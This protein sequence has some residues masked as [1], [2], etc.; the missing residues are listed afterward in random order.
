MAHGPKVKRWDREEY[1]CI[2]RREG[3]ESEQPPHATRALCPGPPP[4]LQVGGEVRGVAGP[5]TEGIPFPPFKGK[6]PFDMLIFGDTEE[7]VTFEFRDGIHTATLPETISFGANKVIG[8]YLKPHFFT[9]PAS[10]D[11]I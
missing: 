10:A 11:G 3:R 8:D 2:G 6:R 5:S 7:M 4:M 1:R 9:V